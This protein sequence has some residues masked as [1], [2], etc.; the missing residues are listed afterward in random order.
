MRNLRKYRKS[1]S[2]KLTCSDAKLIKPIKQT[3]EYVHKQDAL[4]VMFVKYWSFGV[5]NKTKNNSWVYV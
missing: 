2:Y 3:T 1:G 4:L 5:K